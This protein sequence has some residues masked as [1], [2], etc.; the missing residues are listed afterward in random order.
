MLCRVL[1]RHN[2]ADS[3]GL[4]SLALQRMLLVSEV[5]VHLFMTASCGTVLFDL[6]FVLLDLLFIHLAQSLHSKLDIVYERIAP[7]SSCQHFNPYK[8]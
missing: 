6:L 8:A 7:E 1:L 4:A 5:L 3:V 2:L